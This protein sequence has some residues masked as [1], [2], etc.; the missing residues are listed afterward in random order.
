MHKGNARHKG[1]KSAHNGHK[2]GQ[3]NGLAAVA[4]IKI[5]RLE[6]VGLFD[7]PVL[8]REN[9]WPHMPANKVVYR[10]A[11]YACRQQHGHNFAIAQQPGPGHHARGKQ[12]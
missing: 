7:K 12:Q 3:H 6:Q 2:A 5:V 4:L 10:V 8:A 1:R 9:G 11:K